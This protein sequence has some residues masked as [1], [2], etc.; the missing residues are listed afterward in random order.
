MKQLILGSLFIFTLT[1]GKAQVLET[2]VDKTFEGKPLTLLLQDIEE[3]TK[4]KFHYMPDWLR[5][6]EVIILPQ[7]ETLEE[8]LIST[9]SG[10]DISF[11]S[12]YPNSVVF[13]KDP[14]YAFARN[15]ML[16]LAE[17]N[18]IKISKTIVG[19]P[20]N[21]STKHAQLSGKV[22]DSKTLDPIP[23]V[24]IELGNSYGVTTDPDGKFT[25]AL[26]PG[27]HA[28]TFRYLNYESL[29]IDLEIY[30]DG[31]LDISLDKSPHMLEEVIITDK[32]ITDV[33][34][35]R[36][37]QLQLTMRE[38][39]RA[40]AFMGE[41]D[42]IKQIQ[43]LPGVTTVGEAAAGFNVRG[44]SVDQN[45]VLF[46]DMPIFNSSHA[47][48]FLSSFNS[49]IIRDVSFFRGGIPA[50]YGGRNSSVLDIQS[51]EGSFE[52]WSGSGG[53]GLVTSNL[54]VHGPLKKNKT[55][56]LGSF[57]TTYS[58]W[59]INSIRTNYIDLRKS[60]V[61]FYDGTLKLNH[62][63]SEKTIFSL[64][65]YASEDAFSLS[66]DTTYQW[67]NFL[68][69]SRMNH[70][71][72]EQ[73]NGEFQIGFSKYGYAVSNVV[74]E[75]ASK[76]TF[77]INTVRLSSDFHYQLGGHNLT[78]GLQ[79]LLY[80][81]QPG[82]LKPGSELSNANKL[83]LDN[84]FTIE[85]ALYVSDS[86][87]MRKNWNIE[88][89]IRLPLFMAFG[90][91]S[92]YRYNAEVPREPGSVTDTITY[93]RGQ[94]IKA[95][96]GFEPRLSFRWQRSERASIK[97]GYHRINQFLHLITN[98]ASVTPIDIWQPSNFYFKP[99]RADQLSVGYYRDSKSKKYNFFVE[100][101]YKNL[102][103]IIDFKDGAQLVLNPQLETDL[104]QG[105]G[106]AYGIESYVAK[107][108]GRLTGTLNYTYSRSFRII[109]SSF[110]SESIN[111][112]NRYP[113]NFDQ[114]HIANIS[115][116]YSF[117]R[118]HFFTGNFTYHTGRPVT[119]PVSAFE[120]E[121]KPVAFFSSR[122]QY[123]IP[124][125]HRL[126]LALVFEGNHKRKQRWK[127]TWVFSV[128]NVYGRK[129]PYTVFFK[130]DGNGVPVPYQLSIIGI[131]FPAISYTIKI[132]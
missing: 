56:L 71:F 87:T 77:Q 8:T 19:S 53:I 24:T 125:Y 111:Q 30:S 41:A 13:I 82:E 59:L 99:Q 121:G 9:L 61:N 15:R 26:N 55:S 1:L 2:A 66:G 54:A 109:E 98:S 76:L 51:R 118:R 62:K 107:N 74:P 50:E 67:K 23:G 16:N 95:Y 6:F 12:L 63:F 42:L 64:S 69:T 131:P 114:P 58:N 35:S 3:K 17:V 106:F 32:S 60:S 130:N 122:N 83:S 18:E 96:G 14:E 108:T 89:G 45:L 49:E 29:V 47:F 5:A 80:H 102:T 28:L 72:S 104:L 97:F 48:G 65:A 52:K 46:D 92:V 73:L 90:P 132:E 84:Q 91:Q 117:S 115:W 128:Y 78:G 25:V 94:V 4:A 37:G 7:H 88:A 27:A 36:I 10:S 31:I 127:G 21:A 39:K 123:R 105:K 33:T 57:R 112:G 68:V 113:S 70:Q 44:G 11:I 38:I 81:I 101:F 116:K 22:L 93:S 86:W 75:T 129:N 20:D 120:F 43:T 40:P 100:G 126:D 124:D 119:I 34:T 110:A 103:N 79:T 85:N